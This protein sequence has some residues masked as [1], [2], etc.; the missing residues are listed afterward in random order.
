MVSSRLNSDNGHVLAD[1]Q[2]RLEDHDN[3]NETHEAT[4]KLSSL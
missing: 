2:T 1:Q 3:E 4:S